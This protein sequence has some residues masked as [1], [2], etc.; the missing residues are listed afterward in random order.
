M[1][2]CMALIVIGVTLT[3][4]SNLNLVTFDGAPGTTFKFIELNDPVMG[5]QST[6]TW[7]VSKSYGVFDGQVNDVPS[8][9]APGFIKAAA[10]GHFPDVSSA[11]GGSIL[12]SVRST[13]PGYK[14]FRI[15]IAAGAASPAYSCGAGGSLPF[16][17]GCFKAKYSVPAGNNFN[18]VRIP[19]TAFSDKWSSATGEHT[20]ECK[21]D[22]SVCLTAAKLKKIQRVE[23]W[24]EGALGKVHLE[25]Q[26]ISVEAPSQLVHALQE[27]DNDVTYLATFDGVNSTAFSWRDQNDPV[28][29][30]A[31]TSSFQ[32]KQDSSGKYGVFNGTCA[33]VSFLKAPGFAKITTISSALNDASAHIN[34]SLQLRVRSS[35]PGYTGFRLGF[36]A[37]DVPKTSIF[38]GSSFKASFQVNSTDWQVIT[39]PFASFSYDWSGYTGSCDTKDPGLFGHQH[40]CCSAAHPE[41]CPTSKFL[42][43]MTEVDI[44]A[45]GVK[46]DFHLELAD[47]KSVV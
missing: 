22:E 43:T 34:G 39:V 1:K 28:M 15:T 18:T 21:D 12:L 40:H 35:T 47:R 3:H 46:G 30:G 7:N 8:L 36:G 2:N 45:E 10:D 38:G 14:G 20:K 29:G 16:S 27:E 32:V 6:G 23:V 26:S 11:F 25:V 42:A 13:T 19:M 24:A 5:G 37:K 17:T 33:I 4:A 9:K 41:V 31:S 44:W